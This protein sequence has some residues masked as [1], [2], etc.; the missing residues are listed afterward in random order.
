MILINRLSVRVMLQQ[1][2]KHL[3]FLIQLSYPIHQPTNQ[4]TKH[5][6]AEDHAWHQICESKLFND[7]QES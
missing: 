7:S 4:P 3:L 2:D 1:G 5:I 6:G